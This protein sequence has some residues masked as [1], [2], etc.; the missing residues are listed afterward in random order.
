MIHFFLSIIYAEPQEIGLDV[1]MKLLDDGRNYDIAVQGFDGTSRTYRTQELF[2]SQHPSQLIN[3][4]TRV[5]AA[6]R[7]ENG[8]VCGDTVVLKDCWTGRTSLPEPMLLEKM[9][10]SPRPPQYRP[11][12]CS[13][14]VHVEDWGAV[15]MGDTPDTLDCTRRFNLT[16]IWVA[17]PEDEDEFSSGSEASEPSK[18]ILSR[19]FHHRFVFKDVCTPMD[20][21]IFA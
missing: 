18:K 8:Q 10:N 3:K 15:F 21:V 11:P 16:G 12:E 6:V 20:D 9:H 7:V 2:F 19:Q 13:L 4:V 14:F 17:Y 1:T 5:W